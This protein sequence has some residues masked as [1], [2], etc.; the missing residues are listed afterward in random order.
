MAGF[1]V[2]IVKVTGQTESGRSVRPPSD[3]EK[4]IAGF[5]KSFFFKPCQIALPF[6]AKAGY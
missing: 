6:D 4:T 5:A 1:M 2:W 3:P